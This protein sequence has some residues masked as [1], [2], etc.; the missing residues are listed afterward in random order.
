MKREPSAWEY[1]W[2]P[3][4]LE[5][6]ITGPDPPGWRSLESETVIYDHESHG[7]WTREWLCRRGPAAIVND[8]PILLS[9]GAPYNNN[10]EQL[11]HN[12]TNLVLGAVWGLTPRQTYRLTICHN[13]SLTFTLNLTWQPLRTS[14]WT[15]RLSVRQW[16]SRKPVRM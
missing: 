2:A 8:K 12:N 7:M 9:E 14:E 3:L 6:I 13:M 11:S 4:F 15:I 5:D 1:N 10:P 16:E